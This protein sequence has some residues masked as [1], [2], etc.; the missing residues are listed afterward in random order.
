LAISGLISTIPGAVMRNR[1][2]V[3]LPSAPV[4]DAA[5][6]PAA[7]RAAKSFRGRLLHTPAPD[8]WCAS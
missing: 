6:Y 7:G 5:G 3:G 8:Q 4:D 2:H 1:T